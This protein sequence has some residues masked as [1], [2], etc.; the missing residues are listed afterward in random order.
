MDLL[1]VLPE[2]FND[3]VDVVC[4]GRTPESIEG[5]FWYELKEMHM[6]LKYPHSIAKLLIKILRNAKS[7]SYGK[8]DIQDIV[9]ELINLEPKERKALQEVLLQWNI[10][11]PNSLLC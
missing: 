3:V 7:L 2:A 11:I 6:S 9:G 5:L 1:T 10:E 4:K 8:E